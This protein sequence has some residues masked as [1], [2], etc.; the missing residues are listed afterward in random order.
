MTVLCNITEAWRV[1]YPG[2]HVGFLVMITPMLQGT[3][4]SEA[5]VPPGWAHR[6]HTLTGITRA[7]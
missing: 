2:A 3:V 5:M 1:A 4:L 6:G 7:A